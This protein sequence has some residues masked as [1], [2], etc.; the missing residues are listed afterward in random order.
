MKRKKLLVTSTLFI[1]IHALICIPAAL[2]CDSHPT[3]PKFE[4]AFDIGGEPGFITIQDRDGFLW[5]SSFYNG[6][7]RFDGSGKRMIREG[8]EGLSSDFVTQL[9]EDEDGRIWA[10][11]N[12]G[13]NRYDKRTN[14]IK[15]FLNDPLSLDNSLT[16]NV[17]NL[18]SRTIIQDQK[19][20]MWFGTQSGWILPELKDLSSAV[21]K[22]NFNEAAMIHDII[23]KKL[24]EDEAN[25]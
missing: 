4:Y 9:L 19:G 25:G 12:Y 11:T 18:S 2:F 17:F 14:S 24:L 8:S 10:G 3:P 21:Q 13:L 5:F 16:G 6:M 1:L 15:I 7:L 22:Y 20:N 23:F